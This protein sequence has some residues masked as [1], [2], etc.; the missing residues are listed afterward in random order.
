M[1]LGIIWHGTFM[2]GREEIHSKAEKTLLSNNNAAKSTHKLSTKL[3]RFFNAS[4][5]NQLSTK[6]MS[7]VSENLYRTLYVKIFDQ[8]IS[9]MHFPS[10]QGGI[11]KNSFHF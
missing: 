6:C 1:C 3:L 10:V 4:F 5:L 9:E 7:Q 2:T 8:K 11:L